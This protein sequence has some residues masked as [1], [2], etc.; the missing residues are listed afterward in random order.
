MYMIWKMDVHKFMSEITRTALQIITAHGVTKKSEAAEI[1]AVE[2]ELADAGV[3]KNYD[4][5]KGRLRRALFSYFE[6][7]G[8]LDSAQQLT[9][10]GRAFAENRMS[11]QE[12]SY[13]YVLNY[14]HEDYYPTHR[15]L[16]H[17]KEHG[18]LSPF[19]FL[20]LQQDE[21]LNPENERAIGWDIWCYMLTQSGLMVKNHEKN[22][23]IANWGL[24]QKS[25]DFYERRHTRQSL[26]FPLN[27][28]LYGPPGTGKTYSLKKYAAKITGDIGCFTVFTTFHQSYSYEDFIQGL[29]PVPNAGTMTFAPVDGVFK[30]IADQAMHDRGNNYVIIIDEINRANIS[31]VFGELITLIEEDKR[32]GAENE[33]SVT[34][35]SGDTFAVPDNLYIIGTMNSAD[36]SISLIDT[37]LRR[38]F[39][40]I[41]IAPNASL[42]ENETMQQVLE[43]LNKELLKE[44]NSTDLLIG[45]AYFLGKSEADLTNIMNRSIIPLLYEYFFDNEKKVKSIVSK[46][47]ESLDFKIIDEKV[48]RIKIA[49]RI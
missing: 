18:E 34:L 33:L 4:G 35:P 41:E 6:R 28:I 43:N 9:P 44:L 13:Q 32:W 7:Y 40:F 14:K 15:M 36:K 42:I 37:A 38:R 19:Y 12:F 3:Y 25:L 26:G 5:A 27:T 29:R 8:C 23:I 17:L 22:L 45:H 47:F 30:R 21:I 49:Q 16:R 31:K 20:M 11:V 2:R 10:I 46:V 24:A 1:D 39:D 48:G